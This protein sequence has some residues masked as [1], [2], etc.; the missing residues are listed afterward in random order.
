ML[1]ISYLS[2]IVVLFMVPYS[3]GLIILKNSVDWKKALR[4]LW[5][6]PSETHCRI[7]AHLSTSSPLFVQL[8]AC[9]KKKNVKFSA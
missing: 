5:N 9:L 3:G 7:I 2:S 1:K 6:V 8:K 4:V